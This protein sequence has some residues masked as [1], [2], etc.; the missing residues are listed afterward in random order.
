MN[1]PSQAADV[2]QTDP[3]LVR[4]A[5]LSATAINIL[6]LAAAWGGSRSAF[7][8]IV[9]T[10]VVLSAGNAMV[11]L[12]LVPRLGARRAESLRVFANTAGCIVQ[13]HAGGWAL[14]HL[15]WIPFFALFLDRERVGSRAPTA[16]SCLAIASF[17]VYDGAPYDV[18]AAFVVAGLV[19]HFVSNTRVVQIRNLLRERATATESLEKAH[20]ELRAMHERIVA[21]EKLS[22]IGLLSAGIAHEINNPMAFVSSNLRSLQ[23]DFD[24]LRSD[25]ALADEYRNEVIPDTLEGIRRVNTIVADLR[26]FAR[27]DSD[28]M[29]AFDFDEQV[30]ATV[31]IAKSHLR[32]GVAV[33]IVLGAP[34]RMPAGRP[35]QIGQVVMNLVINAG[36]ATADGGTVTIQTG[37][38]HDAV[39]LRVTDTGS[40]MTPE[41]RR[42]LFQPFFTTKRIGEGTGLG[43]SVVHGIVTA[44]HGRID[45]ETELGKGS[46][47]TVTI[48]L[49]P[50]GAKRPQTS[51]PF[52]SGAAIDPEPVAAPGPHDSLT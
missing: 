5:M 4:V 38:E 34:G 15:L 46:T 42:N 37:G 3:E 43:L 29:V 51:S 20:A 45:V 26:R 33:N 40:G 32:P 22:S 48:P 2:N 44:H 35:G 19:A 18:V 24:A 9:A 50:A 21:Q 13:G 23:S 7:L 28:A 1:E 12:V 49:S 6:L 25:P 39:W 30:A 14:P 11:D 16:V 10:I 27:G 8:T 52:F 47:F 41:T 36:H 31:R 17:A